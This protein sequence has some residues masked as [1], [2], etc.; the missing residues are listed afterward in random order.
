MPM[1]G[2]AGSA[3]GVQITLKAIA[4]SVKQG[5]NI[6]EAT[7]G[8]R[9]ATSGENVVSVDIEGEI[10]KI[11]VTGGVVAE[12]VNSDGVHV[13]GGIADLESLSIRAVHGEQVVRTD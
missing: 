5:G 2:R 7:I 9:I 8:G 13:R 4:L 11:E 3:K 10:G 1:T 12:G 6:G